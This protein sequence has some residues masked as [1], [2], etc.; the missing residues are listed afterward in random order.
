[1]GTSTTVRIRQRMS[2]ERMPAHPNSRCMVGRLF[3]PLLGVL[4]ALILLGMPAAV[5]AAMPV[6]CGCMN[7]ITSAPQPCSDHSSVPCKGTAAVCTGAMSC[8]SLTGL[9]EREMP[10]GAWL[11]LSPV[12]YASRDVIFGGRSMKPLLGPPITL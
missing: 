11:A 7:E 1:M 10:V 2:I 4:V 8:V 12:L 5:Q 6:S 3:R 9:P